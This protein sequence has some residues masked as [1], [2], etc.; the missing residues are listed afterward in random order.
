VPIFSRRKEQA[1]QGFVLK[2]V[3]NNCPEL[4]ALIEGP[5]LD[6]RVNLT[7]VVLVVPVE[8]KRTRVE[9]A[10]TAVTKEF[11]ST[12]TAIVLDGPK[13]I[14]EAFLGFRWEGE[15]IFLRAKAKHLSPMGGGF[16]QLGFRMQ[17]MIYPGDHPELSEL[18]F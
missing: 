10:F 5:R 11:S 14:D 18:V 2:V 8:G 6:R 1:V 4:R 9:R 3:N 12:G 13:H 16:F 17:E 7:L 15:L